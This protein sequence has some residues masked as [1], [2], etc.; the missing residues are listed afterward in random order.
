M[1]RHH[2]TQSMSKITHLFLCCELIVPGRYP[3]VTWCRCGGPERVG[4][5]LD[6]QS[7]HPD[8][9]GTTC[10]CPSQPSPTDRAADRD[11]GTVC[12]HSGPSAWSETWT[13][14][15]IKNRVTIQSIETCDTVS[16]AIYCDFFFL[17]LTLEKTVIV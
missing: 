7:S 1:L 3:V 17:N 15:N 6:T 13:N 16:K 11:P 14:K 8:P 5:P 2:A 4:R 12:P 10:C 9:S